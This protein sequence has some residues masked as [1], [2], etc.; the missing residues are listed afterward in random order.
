MLSEQHVCLIPYWNICVSM[1]ANNGL[2]LFVLC[3][4]HM[5]ER[6]G[7]MFVKCLPGSVHTIPL[8]YQPSVVF[9]YGD[10]VELNGMGQKTCDDLQYNTYGWGFQNLNLT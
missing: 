3:C 6:P 2:F 10:I 1:S 8:Y 7:H 4:A 9:F 5:I